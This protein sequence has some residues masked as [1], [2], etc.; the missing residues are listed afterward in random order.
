[1]SPNSVVV[2]GAG[3]VF[4]SDDGLGE[5]AEI[6]A[7]CPGCGQN[8]PYGP[9]GS[10][11]LIG[12]LAVDGAGDIFVP[13]ATQNWVVEIT[14]AGGFPSSVGSGWVSPA[15]AAV[16]AAGDVFVAD[17]GIPAVV[18]VPAGCSSASCQINVGTGWS[19]PESVAV[20]AA[21]DVYVSDIGLNSGAGAIVEV[22]AGCTSNT[23]QITVVSGVTSYGVAVDPTGVVVYV[24]YNSGLK[25]VL[26]Q[27][28]GLGFSP[29]LETI[30]S[31]DSPKSITLQNVG[32]QPLSATG[33]GLSFTDNS[34]YQTPGSGTPA[35]CTTTFSLAAGTTCNVSIDFG[36]LSAGLVTG[37]LYFY[38]NGLN[39]TPF[40]QTF[41][42][43]GTGVPGSGNNWLTVTEPGSGSGTVTSLD[44]LIDCI[45][46]D[47]TVTGTCIAAYP[48]GTTTLTASAGEGSTFTGWG[49]ACSGTGTCVVTMSS[50][51]NVSANFG[52]TNFGSVNVCA[53]GIPAGCSPSTF[54]VTFNFT[55]HDGVA[56]SGVQVVTQGAPNLDFQLGTTTCSGAYAPGGS[57]TVNVNFTPTVP[58]LRLG[59]VNL[60]TSNG[61]MTQFVSGIG[62]AAEAAFISP[63]TETVESTGSY[64]ISVPQG[65]AVDAAG[66]VYISDI[67]NSQVLKIDSTTGQT[68][69][70][71]TAVKEPEGLAVDG[72]G[73][74]LVADPQLDE[75]LEFPAGGGSPTVLYG[76]L[77]ISVVSSP[78]GVAVD[79]AGDIFVADAGFGHV[80][81]LPANGGA[82]TYPYAGTTPRSVAVDAAGDVFVADNL[83]A[84]VTE[85]PVGCDE[86]NTNNCQISIG[87][88]WSVP[89]SVAVDA[90]GDVYVADFQANSGA[91]A[92]IEVTPNCTSN[93]CLITIASG[94]QSFSAA[95]DAAGDVYVADFND[96]SNSVY[97]DQVVEFEQSKPFSLNLGF[98]SEGNPGAF[99]LTTIQNIGNQ[100]LTGSVASTTTPNFTEYA[101]LSTCQSG[102]GI[103][104]APGATCNEDFEFTPTTVGPLNDT[105]VVSDNSLNGS[106]ATQTINL[107]GTGLGSAVNVSVTGTGTG[108]VSTSSF[109]NCAI[110]AG[111]AQSGCSETTN[112][113]YTYTFYESPIVG[114]MFT[115]WGGDCSSNSSGPSC[116]LVITG[117]ANIIANFAPASSYL[118]TVTDL[119][120][121]SGK[122]SSGD[123]QIGCVDTNGTVTGSP[124]CS[125]SYSS[126]TVTLTATASGNSIF[127]GWGGACS[128]SA[129]CMVM[130]SQAQSVTADFVAPGPAVSSLAPI[131]AGVVWGQGGS[132]TS[133]AGNYDGIAAD[134]LN[135]PEN[136]ALDSNGNLYVADLQNSRV[137]YYPAGSTTAT[138]VYGQNGS[139]TTG[140]GAVSATS[141][142]NPYGLAVDSSGGLYI[143][144]WNNNRVLYYSAGS[145]TA[146]AVYGQNGSFSSNT[147]NI[148]GAVDAN[149]LSGPQSVALDSSGNL[150]VADTGNSRVLFYPAGSTTAT[151]VW[152]QG[153]SLTSGN[154]D[155][156]GVAADSLNQPFA[157][158][159]DSS[160]DLYVADDQNNRVL[161][162]PAGSTT[163]TRVYGQGGSFTS[164]AQNYDGV[165]A[166]SLWGPQG[167]ALDSGGN[168]YVADY[169][170]S[171]VLFYPFGSTTATRVYG[172]GGSFTS[173]NSNTDANSLSNP[174]AVVLDNSGNVYVAD[175]SNNRV[176]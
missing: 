6:P 171:R 160:G 106:P 92:I 44:T 155:N 161:F 66:N 134:S 117:P 50:A 115:S 145:T 100:T 152:G 19:Q 89:E 22:P 16:D 25:W 101:A 172:Q 61:T 149:G 68:S 84:T 127:A 165:A 60:S 166:D 8:V 37:N 29:S 136:L 30:L 170:N 107:E 157:I 15:S 143:A 38:D 90:G 26:Q 95:L 109:I 32:N 153:G 57:C 126:G 138:R 42:L 175:K 151:Q 73:D 91:G 76:P 104:L 74:L 53:G 99:Q 125:A 135:Q 167:L 79:G 169:F 12:G 39:N 97:T 62:Q 58:G 86:H 114:T 142:N 70:F 88:G 144:D 121:G 132:F 4:V 119:G 35:D 11:E 63:S 176:V 150:Y 108:N 64:P 78:E 1:M 146:T 174:A 72:A 168:L 5:V 159:L 133:P 75:V 123:G 122:V 129:T 124:S 69:V 81:E 33:P 82:Q 147:A 55:G 103:S 7:G 31:S 52:P 139:F 93:T 67:G 46:G 158:A 112:E 49:G 154:A 2:D 18:E 41:S 163:A 118:L 54:P 120:T 48:S 102:S 105:A 51:Q 28:Y 80:V 24:D 27:F 94:I 20:D 131:T 43:S 162:Y 116:T 13:D 141:L 3:D 36:P 77:P 65:V 34:F 59:A 14:P 111:V 164:S 23:C 148:D 98:S 10:G 85:V 47:G 128:G 140:S 130:M 110:V 113:G 87:T 21:G 40:A 156:D 96:N 71:T 83:S 45:E 137:L 56:V 17:Y 9:Y 173:S